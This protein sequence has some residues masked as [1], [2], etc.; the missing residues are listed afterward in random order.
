MT[1]QDLVL[2]VE[3][4]HV[5]ELNALMLEEREDVGF[6]R[7]GDEIGLHGK[8]PAQRM[9][10]QLVLVPCALALTLLSASI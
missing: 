10:E 1:S 3:H 5:D 7:K 8:R 9:A 2:T 6:R 4:Q